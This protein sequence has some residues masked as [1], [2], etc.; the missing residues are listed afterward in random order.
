[1]PP[2]PAP[3]EFL[4]PPDLKA[5]YFCRVLEE[6]FFAETDS[7][8]AGDYHFSFDGRFYIWPWGFEDG[9]IPWE[10][11]CEILKELR[12][13]PSAFYAQAAELAGAARTAVEAELEAGS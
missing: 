5:A 13:A 9:N 1:M 11:V 12:I 2:L 3:A 6:C 4:E 8:H 10:A 7:G